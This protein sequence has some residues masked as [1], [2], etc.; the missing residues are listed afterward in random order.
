MHV[1]Q[2]KTIFIATFAIAALGSCSDDAEKPVLPEPEPDEPEMVYDFQYR[3]S[4][5]T[6][7]TVNQQPVTGK[8]K[9]NY[10]NCT[11]TIDSDNDAW[12]W[13]GTARIRGRGNSTW[14]WYPKKPYRIKLDEKA[15]ILGLKTEKDW[16]L[17]ANYRDPTH[18]MNNFVFQT[19]QLMGLPYTN[20]TRY[21]EVTLNGD[22]IGIYQLT[23]QVEQGKSRVNINEANGLL[24]S[25][26]LDDGP[27]LNPDGGDNFFSQTYRLPVCVK[28]P[29]DPT[30]E[31]LTAVKAEFAL[32]EEAV[33][34]G[35]YTE[36]NELL[37]VESFIKYIMIQE[38]V[39][40]VELNA[41]RSMFLF[42][43]QGGKWTMGPLWD[44]DGGF[45]FD[46]STMYT[47]HDYFA[48][49][50]E[51]VMSVNPVS[52]GQNGHISP[53]FTDL[54]KHKP[55]VTAYKE[56]WQSVR[57]DILPVYWEETQRY[58]EASA[59]AFDRDNERWPIGKSR[60]HEIERM[61]EWL[62]ERVTY[63]DKIITNYPAGTKE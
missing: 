3:A 32:L 8:G 16:V 34:N 53:F 56:T 60:R 9:E 59:D 49:Y 51:L 43:D 54:F 47:G 35:T 28:H 55:F 39:H 63:L 52:Y 13:Q 25:L 15:E 42:K 46:W 37:N 14:L 19:G 20:N 7:N 62:E 2:V 5:L 50:R 22:Y 45:D 40:N 12:N 29:D 57:N 10:V 17:L 41:P 18:S 30:A 44:F 27:S 24:L 61:R 23:E 4:R 33:K 36:I 48:S 58:M 38:L 31:T 11:V 6:I 21:V 1:K 26:D